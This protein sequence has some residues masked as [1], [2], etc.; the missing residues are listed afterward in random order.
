MKIFK[1]SNDS[2]QLLFSKEMFRVGNIPSVRNKNLKFTK[3][4][5]IHNSLI[6]PCHFNLLEAL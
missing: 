4:S 5:N 6:S 1:N 2:D 3:K